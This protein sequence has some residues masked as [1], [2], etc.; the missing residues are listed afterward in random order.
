VQ[1]IRATAPTGRSIVG[2]APVGVVRYPASEKPADIDAARRA[3]FAIDDGVNSWNSNTWYSDPIL[4]GHYPEDGLKLFVSDVPRIAARDFETMHQPLDFYGVNIY[5]GSPVEHSAT[6]GQPQEIPRPPGH[7]TTAYKWTIDPESL[8]WGPRF[9]YE[10]YQLPILIAENGL[11][12]P[13]WIA[14]DGHCHD[15]QRIDFARRYL[16][17]VH[18]AIQD[19]I[20]IRAY[21]HWSILDNF[22]WHQGYTERFGLIHVDFQT[23]KRTPKDSYYWYAEIIRTNGQEIETFGSDGRSPRLEATMHAAQPRERA[24][25]Q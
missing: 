18:R 19:R 20:D 15:P 7:P 21:F 16:T 17:Q 14:L 12:N 10:R 5:N 2:C 8:Y 25:K 3:T 24:I 13:D 1:T 4:L 22:E 6:T 23:Q 11:S 9:L